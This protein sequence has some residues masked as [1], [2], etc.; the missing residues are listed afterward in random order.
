MPAIARGIVIGAGVP[1]IIAPIVGET[2]EKILGSAREISGR[3]V[4]V[5]EWRADFYGDAGD[6]AKVVRTL[7]KLRAVLGRIPV[8]FTYRSAREGGRG[9]MP[10]EGYTALNLAAAASGEADIVDVEIM[11]GDEVV[12][13]NIANIHG[14]GAIV[15]GSY[16]DF[17]KTPSEQEIIGKLRRM[18]EAGA[19]ILKI[20]VMPRRKEDVITLISATEKM[21]EEYAERPLVT[22]SMS[23]LGVASRLFGE[24]FGSS[25]TFGAVGETS[26]PGQIPV[27][28]L[29]T[30]LTILHQSM[31]KG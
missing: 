15:I 23:G 10:A 20:A 30:V 12:A 6:S 5:V 27:E 7:E 13:E 3:K 22:M 25:M 4:D 9:T 31:L 28:Q 17:E 19:D 16:H 24:C 26:A 8:L 2:Q 1:K 29:G 14:K 18:Q 11:S 21:Y